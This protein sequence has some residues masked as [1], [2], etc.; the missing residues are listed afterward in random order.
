MS[1]RSVRKVYSIDLRSDESY[2]IMKHR[3][4]RLVGGTGWP[5]VLFM[6][7][8][9][10]IPLSV[11][12]FFLDVGTEVVLP[13]EPLIGI[14]AIGIMIKLFIAVRADGLSSLVPKDAVSWVLLLH[15][16]WSILT[17][18]F[19]QDLLV[20]AKAMVVRTCYL[21]VFYIAIR[22]LVR[23]GGDRF[24]RVMVA[25]GIGLMVVVLFVM[26]RCLDGG[27]TRNIA[28]YAPFPFYN[29][30]TSYAAAL[31]FLAIHAWSVAS[32][33]L[34]HKRKV[35]P[36]LSIFLLLL[37]LLVSFSRAGWLS[38]LVALVLGS[39]IVLRIRLAHVAAV[40]AVLVIAT[41]V[42]RRAQSPPDHTPIDSYSP[43]A[44]YKVSLVTM[45]DFSHDSSNKERLNRWKS[46]LRMARER[47]FLGYGP[48]TFQFFYIQHQRVED[49]THYTVDSLVA[50]PYVTKTWSAGPDV[51]IRTNPQVLFM[52][53]G[54]AHSEY[55]LALSETGVIGLLLFGAFFTVVLW[56][57]WVLRAQPLVLYALLAVAAYA[58]HALVNN[59]LDDPKIAYL[60]YGAAAVISA[61]DLTV[62]RGLGLT[63]LRSWL[64][65]SAKQ[66]RSLEE[67]DQ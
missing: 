44:G 33:Q 63:G 53:G 52:S 23:A 58:V 54:T 13:V 18:L 1:D 26:L 14:F 49:R 3:L 48:G 32:A 29:D 20:S 19:S 5:W 7:M 6:V 40:L 60:F 4:E 65:Q 43:D 41:V 30:H 37:A 11:K 21:L 39:V 59:F 31:V 16:M 64:V 15:F 42:V 38:A 28:G 46:A 12:V 35:I 10:S 45:F 67:P 9:F 66:D 57:A 62:R 47:P 24:N 50:M 55:L 8:S 2:A 34:H 22:E 25:Y 61:Q 51:F 27:F 17:A 36:Y 56:R